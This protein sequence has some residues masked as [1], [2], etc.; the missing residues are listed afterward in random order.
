MAEGHRERLKT[1]FRTEG[2][3]NFND[4][5]AL[6]LILFYA[7]PRSDTNPLAHRLLDRF[8]SFSAVLDA[9]YDDLMEVRGVSDHTA[10]YLKLL[11]E[12][13][14]YYQS[15][16]ITEKTEL[17]TLSDI[18]EFLVRKYVGVIKET[19]YMLLLDNKRCLI[20]VE[21]LHEGS[22]SSAAVSVRKMAEIALKKRAAA[23][24]IAHN[25]PSGLAVPSPDDIM[26][27][28]NFKQ[29]LD[30]LEIEFI[31]HFVVAENKYCTILNRIV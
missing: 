5:N 18:G 6:E 29:A 2:L 7:V 31:D 25:H 23:I 24:V 13:A 30:T 12:A 16:K 15:S 26:A 22:V 4:I 9:D 1:R 28:R 21:K 20:G 3:D 17:A 19:V 11:P 8:G 10:T 14:R 27:T